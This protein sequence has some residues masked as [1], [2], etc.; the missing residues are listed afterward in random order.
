M[1]ESC[2]VSKRAPGFI[3]SVSEPA[4]MRRYFPP[5]TPSLITSSALSAGIARPLRTLIVTCA[6]RLFG[7]SSILT[8]EPT[9]MPE[10]YTGL[11]VASPSTWPNRAVSR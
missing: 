10:R 2:T 4:S 8:T 6:F 7:A 3:A 1:T 9:W 11:P 5:S